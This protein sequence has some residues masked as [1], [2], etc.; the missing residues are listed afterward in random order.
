MTRRIDGCSR[1]DNGKAPRSLR[2]VLRRRLLD[3]R[4]LQGAQIHLRMPCAEMKEGGVVDLKK[5][6]TIAIEP[7]RLESL[8]RTSKSR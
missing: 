8:W 3:V 2:A 6:L 1:L 4:V 5:N 7:D